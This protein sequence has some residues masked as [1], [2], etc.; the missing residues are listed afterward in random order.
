MRSSARFT[1]KSGRNR[2]VPLCKA[3]AELLEPHRGSPGEYILRPDLV[4]RKGRRWNFIKSFNR[5][6][7][8]A[9]VEWLTVHDLRRSFATSAVHAGVSIWKVKNLKT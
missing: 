9:G 2:E 8:E 6:A 1:T 5:V 7:K 4:R 3:L